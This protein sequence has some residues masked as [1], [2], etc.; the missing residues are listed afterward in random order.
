MT[1]VI[2]EFNL[3]DFETKIR[4]IVSELLAPTIRK[5]TEHEEQIQK[6]KRH[7]AQR[8]KDFEE[9]TFN[10]DKL[11]RKSQGYDELGRKTHEMFENL[12]V[13]DAHFVH[14]LEALAT[15][16][17]EAKIQISDF[18]N[19]IKNHD[20]GQK[21]FK[22]DMEENFK[23]LNSYKKWIQEETNKIEADIK[24]MMVN[25]NK[26]T[27]EMMEKI[28]KCENRI[29]ELNNKGIPEI[30][31]DIGMIKREIEIV[32]NNV[33]EN[34]AR[35]MDLKKSKAG[36]IELRE[37]R[38]EIDSIIEEKSKYL[39]MEDKKIIEYISK[40]FKKEID[41][42]L[43]EKLCEI[44]DIKSVKK[45][46]A[47]QE[48][49]EEQTKSIEIP[50]EIPEL[51]ERA[52]I[53]IS[54]QISQLETLKQKIEEEEEK[55][56]II[57]EVNVQRRIA[58]RTGSSMSPSRS[59]SPPKVSNTKLVSYPTNFQSFSVLTDENMTQYRQSV[60]SEMSDAS[61]HEDKSNEENKYQKD[62]V[63]SISALNEDA[64]SVMYN[65]DGQPHNEIF[66]DNA[67]TDR[68]YEESLENYVEAELQILRD[69]IEK[70]SENKSE[71][72]ELINLSVSKLS[73]S[74]S[75]QQKDYQTGFSM[76]HSEINLMMK[77]RTKDAVDINNEIQK[78]RQDLSGRDSAF[79]KL[80][81]KILT[82]SI[83]LSA[84]IEFSKVLHQL[85]FQDEEDREAIHL[86]G[87]SDSSQKPKTPST[88]SRQ[89]VSLKP[90]C[91]SC[92]GQNPILLS[93]FKMAC[94]NYSPSNIKYRNHSY[95]RKQLISMVGNFLKESWNSASGQEPFDNIVLP[96]MCEEAPLPPPS[97]RRTRRSS[98]LDFNSSRV[99]FDLS[100]GTP[101]SSHRDLR[102]SF[103][104]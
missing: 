82:L 81:Q 42:N 90:E 56:R 104:M 63:I 44:L 28:E 46:I 1:A 30:G 13:Q 74:I 52:Q 102:N 32:K 93:A 97:S 26:E 41:V 37:Y 69:S 47:Y 23:K 34:A 3:F 33:T 19:R 50:K 40:D 99:N 79:S 38:K 84:L 2:S 35:I 57:K 89:I 8:Q 25:L 62:T 58:S 61:F 4:G 39:L 91:V 100:A 101:L 54:N 64:E 21:S 7:D 22:Q 92:T 10:V 72:T 68:E 88:K 24:K 73:E 53:L 45:L 15:G 27:E 80:D 17:E 86:S 71:L 59:R 77:K 12:R 76:L 83:L 70:L 87:Y 78:L 75:N 9:M 29:N 55:A 14:K 31:V 85:V 20:D 6:L 96:H 48:K 43:N 11:I 95:S 36:V 51:Q 5:G 98:L 18:Q 103:H 94:L 65:Q 60:A 67:E 16:V 49:V 66:V